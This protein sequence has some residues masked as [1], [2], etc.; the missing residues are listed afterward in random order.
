LMQLYLLDQYGKEFVRALATNELQGI[1]SA[2]AVLEDF[3]TGIDFSELFRRFTI[4]VA[5]D[6]DKPGD[7]T[8]NFESIDINVNYESALEYDKDGVPAWGGDYKA[9][10]EPN[11]I[12]NIKFDGISFMPTP[13]KVVDDPLGANEKVLWGNNGHLADN[14]LILEAD[15]TGTDT[16]TLTF[17]TF[18]DIEPGW[19]AGIVQ[20]S[21]DNGETW[22]SLANEDTI[23]QDEFDLND[24]AP[25]IYNNLPGFSVNNEDWVN[26]TFDLTPYAGQQIL[27]NFRYMTDGAYNDSGWFID[28]INIPEI[29]YNNDCSSLDSFMSIDELNQVYVEYAV[30]FINEKTRGKAKKQQYYRVLN[31]DPFN[32]TE[33]D[34]ITLK[35][36][37]SGGNTYMVIW[38]AAP[39]GTKGT[40]DY[41]YEITTKSEYNQNK[42][43]GNKKKKR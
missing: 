28:N 17:D 35:D 38:Y 32:V 42:D 8:Y 41:T 1:E 40:V 25:E 12:H 19:D 7:G 33:A 16:A 43:K 21:T 9:L 6:S 36:F 13:W 4:A 10:E 20:V 23:D 3:N 26:E 11:K 2:N 31:I 22:T 14:Q 24:Q 5:I 15:L 37:F 39:E 30:T 18:I 29:E 27:I 34:A